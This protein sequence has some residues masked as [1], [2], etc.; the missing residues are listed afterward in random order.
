MTEEILLFRFGKS[1]ENKIDSQEVFE[2][3]FNHLKKHKKLLFTT[4]SRIKIPTHC[5]EIIFVNH[6]KN[7]CFKAFI[8]GSGKFADSTPTEGYDV[9]SELKHLLQQEVKD[10]YG[11]FAVSAENISIES[12]SK[13][14]YRLARIEVI[15]SLGENQTPHRYVLPFTNDN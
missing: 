7:Q 6:D 4:D 5:E 3:H 12:L 14:Q 11:W 10:G 9:P 8:D 15:D 2:H 1:D 13:G